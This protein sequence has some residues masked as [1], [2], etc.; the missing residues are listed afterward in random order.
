MH[1]HPSS[2]KLRSSW[3]PLIIHRLPIHPSMW[4]WVISRD[5][6]QSAVCIKCTVNKELH[7]FFVLFCRCGRFL[8]FVEKYIVQSFHC[9]G[10]HVFIMVFLLSSLP[11]DFMRQET[12]EGN[13]NE[14]ISWCS[15]KYD[16]MLFCSSLIDYIVS[17]SRKEICPIYLFYATIKIIFMDFLC[18]WFP[19]YQCTLYHPQWVIVSEWRWVNDSSA[20][21]ARTTIF[22]DCA[23][24]PLTWPFVIKMYTVHKARRRIVMQFIG[25]PSATKVHWY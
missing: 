7:R 25:F 16:F 9:S 24:D 13:I 4:S 1:I 21:I 10:L 18:I 5:A 17:L 20:C 3:A 8:L 6:L 19:Q 22:I 2:E 11:P 12:D 15:Y 14:W 23:S